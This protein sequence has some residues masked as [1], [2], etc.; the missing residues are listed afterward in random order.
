MTV[1]V[2][3]TRTLPYVLR[4]ALARTALQLEI[5]EVAAVSDAN[6]VTVTQDGV[7][8][9]ISRL[10]SYTPTVGEAVYILVASSL[11]LAL[12]SVGGTS[13]GGGGGSGYLDG[14][15]PDSTYGGIAPIDGGGV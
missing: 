1:H 14:G 15:E 12:G 8:T 6:T 7:E 5:A 2:P 10:A 9:T 4:Q 13:A 3:V 11:M